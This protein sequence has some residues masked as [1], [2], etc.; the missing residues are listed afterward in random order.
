LSV[1]NLFHEM[2]FKCLKKAPKF[3]ERKPPCTRWSRL[4]VERNRVSLSLVWV[5]SEKCFKNVHLININNMLCQLIA[6]KKRFITVYGFSKFSI[7]I[8]WQ[9]VRKNPYRIIDLSCSVISDLYLPILK[10]SV[11]YFT[12]QTSRSVNN[13]LISFIIQGKGKNVHPHM[14]Y[15]N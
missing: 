10:T 7:L 3:T 14:H 6:N 12:V 15:I 13:T 9:A 11:W 1:N 5:L 8:G 4:W 2:P